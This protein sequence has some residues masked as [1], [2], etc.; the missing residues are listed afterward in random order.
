[1]VQDK[2][3]GKIPSTYCETHRPYSTLRNAQNTNFIL[4]RRNW[5]ERHW[6]YSGHYPRIFVAPKNAQ[7]AETK[8]QPG[9]VPILLLA[10]LASTTGAYS[11]LGV[12]QGLNPQR[13]LLKASVYHSATS[14]VL[15]PPGIADQ[16]DLDP[17]ISNPGLHHPTKKT[18]CGDQ[19]SLDTTT[20]LSAA[21]ASL[22]L[23]PLG[24]SLIVSTV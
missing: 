15:V 4:A 19:A 10:I 24:K 13:Q 12:L 2:E 16:G 21:S 14:A 18:F 8:H 23:A 5:A 1:M 22:A 11:S 20:L 7:N 3:A 6:V 17:Y 9:A